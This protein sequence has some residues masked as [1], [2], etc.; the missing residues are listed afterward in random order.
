MLRKKST[1]VSKINKNY[2]KVKTKE[3][4]KTMLKRIRKHVKKYEMA[5]RRYIKTYNS[6][7]KF[8]LNVRIKKNK[9]FHV[10]LQC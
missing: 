3:I 2:R 8:L 6:V 9:L 10:V 4:N 7:L 5:I 1:T